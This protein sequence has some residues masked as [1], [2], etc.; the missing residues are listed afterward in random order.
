MILENGLEFFYSIDI[1]SIIYRTE[2]VL[3]IHEYSLRKICFEFV[4]RFVL[5]LLEEEINLSRDKN[6]PLTWCFNLSRDII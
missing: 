1:S 5:L 2:T 4:K 3:S 6:C